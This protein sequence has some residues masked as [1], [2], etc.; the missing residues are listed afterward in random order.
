M[1][2]RPDP[3]LLP[4][5]LALIAASPARAQNPVEAVRQYVDRNGAAIVAELR[6]L[7]AIPNVASDRVN[8]RR[9]ADALVAMLQKRGVTTR[10]LETGGPPIVYGEIGNASLPTILFYC[11]YD[12]QPVDPTK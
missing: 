6:E 10:I 4:I 7:V 11:H 3:S 9:N 5:L 1:R 2:T 12:G 8:I